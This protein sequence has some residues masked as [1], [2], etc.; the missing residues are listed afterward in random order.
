MLE[1]RNLSISFRQYEGEDQTPIRGVDFSLAEGQL[2]G[3]VGGS[4]AGKSLVAEALIGNLP[5]NALVSG[6]IT[7]DGGPPRTADIALAPQGRDALDPMCR[8]GAQVSRFAKLA[9]NNCNVETLFRSLGLDPSAQHLWPHELSGGM[10]KRVL[11]ATALAT[12][13][14]ILIADEPTVGLD[15]DA[16]DTILALLS[17]LAA[18][19]QSVLVISHDLPR[20]VKV[21]DRLVILKDGQQVDIADASAFTNNQLRHPYTRSLWKAQNW[22]EF[23]IHSNWSGTASC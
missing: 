23:D 1:V 3:L 20:L 19:G 4:G 11:V 15:P 14:R 12:G 21:A 7:L 13:A 18:Q 6:S 10:A 2:V 5:R 9:G 16:A 22:Q 8:A 17:D